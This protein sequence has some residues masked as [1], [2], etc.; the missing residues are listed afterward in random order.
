[1]V[2][3]NWLGKPIWGEEEEINYKEEKMSPDASEFNTNAVAD[4]D[5]KDGDL[6]TIMGAGEWVEFEDKQSKEKRKRLKIPI[7]CVDGGIKEVALN[8]TSNKALVAGYGKLSEGWVGKSA[9]VNI[10]TKDVFGQF[11]KVIYLNPVR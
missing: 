4:V 6:V 10:V 8:D 3:L 7:K 11:K 9:L 5:V 2:D 1:M